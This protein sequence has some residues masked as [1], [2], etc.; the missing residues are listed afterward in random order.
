MAV[1]SKSP[2]EIAGFKQ[3]LVSV[4]TSVSQASKE[5]GVFGIGGTPVSDSERRRSSS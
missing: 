4:A 1:E 3:W 2:D 5:G